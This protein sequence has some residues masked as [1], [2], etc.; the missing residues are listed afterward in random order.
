MAVSEVKV[1][2]IVPF[3]GVEKY[4]GACAESLMRQTA[5]RDC[6]FIFVDDG[7]KDGSLAVLQEVLSRYPD[8]RVQLVRK[9]N[10]GLPQARLTGLKQ[11]SGTFVLH[12]DS[13]DWMEKD[14]VEK[15]LSAVQEAGADMAYC[16]VANEYRNG[17][18]RVS[19]DRNYTTCRDYAYAMLHFHAHGYLC[20]KL[21]RRSLFRQD[22][23]YPTIGMHEDMVLLG[24]ILY[25]GGACVRVRRPLY[26]YRR[27][28]ESSISGEMKACR[29]AQSARN[30]L[31]LIAFWRGRDH[32]PLQASLPYLYAYCGW[33]A[34]RYDASLLQDF[35]F[36]KEEVLSLTCSTLRIKYQYRLMRV[37]H[38][39][40]SI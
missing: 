27:D 34:L 30:F 3:Y 37:K 26:H 11:A 6:E 2:V 10:G 22:V 28:S 19:W 25:Y 33:K 31:Q 1:S 38:W 9:E 40:K 15:L 16:Y 7:S 36:L 13:D 29:D 5:W 39:L 17:R 32:N 23:F 21:I 4:M 35:P 18:H 24:Q 12:V 14:T 20:N 8:R